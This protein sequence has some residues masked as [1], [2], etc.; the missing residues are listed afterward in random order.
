MKIKVNGSL[1]DY[2]N[3][4]INILRILQDQNVERPELVAVQLNGEF[5]NSSDFESTTVKENDEIDFLFP[6]G[7]GSI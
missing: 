4:D 2:N 5:V 6:M 1:K 3:L 7:G